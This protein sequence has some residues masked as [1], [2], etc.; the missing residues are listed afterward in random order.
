MVFSLHFAYLFICLISTYRNRNIL[1]QWQQQQV[2]NN[3]I[4]SADRL[5]VGSLPLEGWQIGKRWSIMASSEGS[6]NRINRHH[7]TISALWS[8]INISGFWADVVAY[9]SLFIKAAIEPTYGASVPFLEEYCTTWKCWLWHCSVTIEL[10]NE[11]VS[12]CNSTGQ[13][14]KKN[15]QSKTPFV[16][17]VRRTYL[18]RW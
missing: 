3:I 13:S 11:K 2:K 4:T 7:G 5:S 18:P 1:L 12:Q 15:H 17:G 16:L 14:F 10:F 6:I 9:V 8:L